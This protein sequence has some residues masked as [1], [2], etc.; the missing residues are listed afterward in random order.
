VTNSDSRR[1]SSKN[2]L[3]GRDR[4]LAVIGEFLRRVRVRSDSLIFLGEAGIGKTALLDA[5]AEAAAASGI[6]VLRAGGVQF[7]AEVSFSGLHQLLLPLH[8]DF[9]LLQ[10]PQREALNV[11]LGFGGGDAPSQLVVANAMLA[12]MGIASAAQPVLMVVDDLPWVDRASAGALGLV[13]RRAGGA[14]VGLLAASRTDEESFFNRAGLP[15]Y[16]LAA[17]EP[18]D[19]TELMNTRFPGLASAVRDRLL[20]EAEG[21]PLAVLELPAALSGPQRAAARALPAVLPLTRRL[22]GLFAAKVA[23]MPGETQTLLLLIALSG[24]S[25]RQVLGATGRSPADVE[26]LVSAEKARLVSIDSTTGHLMFR[27]PLIRSVVVDMSTVPQRRRAHATL[28]GLA[29]DDPDRRAWHLGAAAKEPDET[30]AGLLEQSAHRM[31]RRGDAV[32]TVAALTRAAELSPDRADGGRRLAEAAYVGADLTGALKSVSQVLQE[33]RNLDPNFT[34]S[35]Q[36]A[37]ASAFMLLNGDGDVPTA[38]RLLVGAVEQAVYGEGAESP[39]LEDALYTLLHVCFFG[40]RAQLWEPFH[41]AAEHLGA[42]FPLTVELVGATTSDP[43]R[44]ASGALERI[45]AAIETLAEESDPK[46]IVRISIAGIFVD[47]VGGCRDSML[48]V[49]H[50]ARGGGAITGGINALITLSFDEFWSGQWEDAKPHLDEALDLCTEHGYLV[51]AAPARQM[52]ALIAAARGEYETTEALT[53]DMLQF[54][55]PRQLRSIQW[56]AWGARALA[57]LGR[58]DYEDAYEQATKI[59]PAGSLGSHNPYVLWH[60][61]DLVEAAVHS[62]HQA[63]AALHARAVEES[64]MAALSPRLALVTNSVV[65][66]AT[67]EDS[68]LPRFAAALAIPGAQRWQWDMARVQLAYGERL[69]RT[70]ALVESRSQLRA[71]LDTFVRLQAHPWADRAAQELR[72]T[73]QTK[74]RADLRQRYSL[75]PQELEIATLAATGLSNKEI[76][77]RLFMS[78]R[79]VG[80]HLYQIFPKLEIRSRAALRDALSTLVDD[81][82]ASRWRQ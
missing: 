20:S 41:R 16:E 78:H 42:S 64:E 69:R 58:G 80:A 74:P 75:T 7:E 32:G 39:A 77:A 62:G 76:G 9:P 53:D 29:A 36:A 49:I 4:E 61:M 44:T 14:R 6:R 1:P 43:L 66:M 81:Q 13:V 23:E 10:A 67:P 68:A 30:V 45:D 26:D 8:D 51:Y 46:R 79:T 24:R 65:A 50:D 31:L 54:A 73:G 40:G 22:Q 27:H 72:A 47:R 60:T 71:A 17:L 2:A 70:R 52:L 15:E 82:R 48:R 35:L 18:A 12:L 3:L 33:I 38:H 28:A 63:E 37:V 56:Q 5:A 57:A 34:S 55:T 21:N 11:A 25:D 19:A 59:C